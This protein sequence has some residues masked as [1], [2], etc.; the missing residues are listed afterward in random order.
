MKFIADN[1]LENKIKTEI[2]KLEDASQFYKFNLKIKI[3]RF[4]FSNYEVNKKIQHFYINSFK[5][6]RKKHFLK[7]LFIELK[8]C[9][10]DSKLK[11]IDDLVSAM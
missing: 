8:R 9:R 4:I 5:T 3:F 1:K 6:K 2:L 11:E 7:F 10:T